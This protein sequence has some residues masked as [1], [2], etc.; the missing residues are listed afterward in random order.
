MIETNH[1]TT[2]LALASCLV[3]ILADEDL[4]TM[5]NLLAVVR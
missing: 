4:Q 3:H 2:T 1:K 5:A